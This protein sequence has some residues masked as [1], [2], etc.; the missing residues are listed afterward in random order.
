MK[1]TLLR[2]GLLAAVTLITMQSPFAQSNFM[3]GAKGGIDIPNLKGSTDNPVS[4]GWGTRLGPY[5]GIV[6][7]Y[8]LDEKWGLQAELNYSSQGA[9]KN[10]NQALPTTAL[11]SNPPPGSP[12]YVW[13]DMNN[14][15]KLNYI[16]LPILAKLKL[17]LGQSLYFMADGGPYFGYL[18]GARQKSKGNTNFYADEAHT[19]ALLTGPIG[20]DEN[21]D[22][23]DE[24]KKFNMGIQLGVGLAVNAPGGEIML[25]LGGNLGF[26]PVQKDK[27]NGQNLTGAINA[28]VGYLFRL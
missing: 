26:I 12:E 14:E 9:K 3:L 23:K 7:C 13:A 4:N 2:L 17:P 21:I 10:G 1:N 18:V 28:T 27:N 20:F 11:V 16:E 5:F 22:I 15:T 19:Q 6:S 24:I 25:T 8:K